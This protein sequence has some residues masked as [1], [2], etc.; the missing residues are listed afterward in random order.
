[1]AKDKKN[2]KVKPV[3]KAVKI[4]EEKTKPDICGYEIISYLSEGTDGAVYKV[5][6]KNG[7]FFAAKK[8][9][10]NWLRNNASLLELEVLTT[11]KHENIINAHKFFTSFN[12]PDAKSLVI[13]VDIAEQDLRT[14]IENNHRKSLKKLFFYIFQI[15]QGLNF[16]HQNNVLHLDIKNKNVV[17]V[18]GT[19]KIIDFGASFYCEDHFYDDSLHTTEPYRTPENL[20]KEI[21]GEYGYYFSKDNDI[22][23]TILIM[24]YGILG[25]S[26]SGVKRLHSY[27]TSL[28]SKNKEKEIGK[29]LLKAGEFQDVDKKDLLN[30]ASFLEFYLFYKAK[31]RPTMDDILKHPLFS[32]YHANS[33]GSIA[34]SIIFEKNDKNTRNNIE[35]PMISLVCILLKKS[36]LKTYYFF[37]AFELLFRLYPTFYYNTNYLVQSIS[38]IIFN[39]TFPA[40]YKVEDFDFLSEVVSYLEGNITINKLY[41]HCRNLK[42]LV[43]AWNKLLKPVLKGNYKIYENY[44]Y[45]Y[46]LKDAENNKFKAKS[47]NKDITIKNF[48]NIIGLKIIDNELIF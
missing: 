44:D 13:I 11:F 26:F 22:W 43:F 40:S 7:K 39:L 18:K 6:D 17:L 2:K 19:I 36:H 24:I 33:T 42:D 30:L 12:C 21:A 10:N 48:V 25:D 34:K 29:I 32:S 45:S 15:L 3:K 23:A 37:L 38:Y 8:Y 9:V 20:S 46:F 28:T 35:D 4:K 41:N 27:F 31:D 16:L 5:Q 14:F 1:M 47:E